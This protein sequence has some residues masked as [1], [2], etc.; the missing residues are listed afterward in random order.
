MYLKIQIYN[1][2]KKKQ[3]DKAHYKNFVIIT[4]QNQKQKI[5]PN[6]NRKGNLLMQTTKIYCQVLKILPLSFCLIN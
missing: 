6:Q 4:K 1:F 2:I 5:T 3:H